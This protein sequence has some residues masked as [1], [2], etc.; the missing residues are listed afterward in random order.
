MNNASFETLALGFLVITQLVVL[1][2]V[3]RISKKIEKRK[4]NKASQKVQR[5]DD[6]R[7]DK[8]NRNDK[9]SN[10]RNR[11]QGKGQKRNQSQGKSQKQKPQQRQ[12]SAVDKSL[13]EINL[14]LK[15]AEKAQEK[16]REEL[17]NS[18][19]SENKKGESRPGKIKRRSDNIKKDVQE[20]SG[21]SRIKRRNL[22]EKPE[23]AAPAEKSASVVEEKTVETSKVK[24]KPAEPVVEQESETIQEET[25]TFGRR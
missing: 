8:R 25:V 4:H 5:R 19:S 7:N 24:L 3:F 14:R 2:K 23:V 6:N 20:N 15:D 10:N 1:V 18:D 17:E 12:V 22:N 9:N 21:E 16:T 13:R 11:A